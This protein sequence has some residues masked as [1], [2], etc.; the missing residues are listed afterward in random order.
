MGK[1]FKP[2]DKTLQEEFPC[3]ERRPQHSRGQNSLLSELTKIFT[4][5][6]GSDNILNVKLFVLSAF[7]PSDTGSEF[8]SVGC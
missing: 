4:S 1:L 5:T 8:L 7:P 2:E 3:R 6:E